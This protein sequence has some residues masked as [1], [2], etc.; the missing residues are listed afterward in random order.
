MGL[1]RNQGGRQ[2][3]RDLRQASRARLAAQ[4]RARL[5]QSVDQGRADLRDA[6]PLIACDAMVLMDAAFYSVV[7]PGLGEA[8]SPE[9]MNTGLWNMGSGFAAPLGA[10]VRAPA[11]W[12]MCDVP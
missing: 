6:D 8:E 9:P 4:N 10:R 12:S 11:G 2:L 3:R 7:I 5:Q 1:Q